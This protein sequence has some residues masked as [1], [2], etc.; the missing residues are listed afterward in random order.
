MTALLTRTMTSNMQRAEAIAGPGHAEARRLAETEFQRVLALLESLE[1]NDWRQPTYCTE[2]NVRDMAAHLAGGMAATAR[3]SNFLRYYVRNPYLK[4][5]DKMEDAANRL[6]IEE[7]ARLT[8]PEVI[9]EFRATGPASIRNRARLPWLVRKIRLPMGST[10]GFSPLDYLTDVIYPRD[11][12]MHRYDICAATRKEMVITAEHDG[13]IT[14]LVLWDVARKLK[15][16]LQGRTVALRLAGPAG[17]DYLF[18]PGGAPDCSIATD[19]F[20]LHLRASGRITTEE[21]APRAIV[22]GDQGIATWFL[23]NLEVPY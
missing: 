11:E 15:R 1:G 22:K 19:I 6:Q 8:A 4:V 7:R 3:L 13:R 20:S 17:G 9:A 23:E 2:W 18:G 14:A 5:M 10:L 21:I 12:W 16:T